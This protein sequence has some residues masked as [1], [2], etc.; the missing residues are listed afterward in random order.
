MRARIAPSA[1]VMFVMVFRRLK[2][3]IEALNWR[4]WPLSF[5]RNLLFAPK[6]KTSTELHRMQVSI[7]A[8]VVFYSTLKQGE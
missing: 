6:T 3:C 7:S 2:R 5:K 1:V 4:V 8:A